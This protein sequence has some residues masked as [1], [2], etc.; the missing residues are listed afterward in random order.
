MDSQGNILEVGDKAYFANHWTIQ[1]VT[2]TELIENLNSYIVT[3][4]NGNVNSAHPESLVLVNKREWPD[5]LHSTHTN[6]RTSWS[7]RYDQVCDDCGN[8]DY[9]PGAWG[10]LRKPCKGK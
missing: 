9:G 6:V 10:D 8:T 7:D 3:L 4:P 1:V 2:V 5:T